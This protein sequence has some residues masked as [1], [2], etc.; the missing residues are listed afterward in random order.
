MTM[1]KFDYGE[2]LGGFLFQKIWVSGNI[3]RGKRS[4]LGVLCQCKIRD[5]HDKTSGSVKEMK[6]H[7]GKE[8]RNMIS[9]ENLVH[10]IHRQRF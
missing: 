9:P 4:P 10:L 8:I 1:D 2:W 7:I 3:E 5:W 6:S